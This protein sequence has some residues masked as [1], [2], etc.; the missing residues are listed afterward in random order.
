MRRGGGEG[1]GV[2]ALGFGIERIERARR[3]ILC[4]RE[5]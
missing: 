4:R 5:R 3:K 2:R 1:S